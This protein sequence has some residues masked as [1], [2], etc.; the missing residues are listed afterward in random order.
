MAGLILSL[1]IVGG[2]VAS[3]PDAVVAQ[4]P[5]TE[6]IEVRVAASTDDAEEAPDGGM[7]LSSSDLELVY[8]GGNQT[9]GMRFNG[10]HIP[11]G[12]PIVNAYLQ[13]Q[14]DETGSIETSLTIA[15]QDADNAAT[16][17]SSDF[18][19]SSRPRT[20]ATVAWSPAP[21]LLK[22]EAGPDQR[23]PDI[24]SVIQEIVDRPGWVSGNSLAIIVTGTGER[25]AES[26]NGDPA[27]AP[28]LRVEYVAGQPPVTTI[29]APLDGATFTTEDLITFSGS[30]TDPEDGDVTASLSWVSNL[31]GPLGNG[32]IFTHPGLSAGVHTITATAIDSGG[33]TGSDQITITVTSPSGNLSPVVSAGPDQAI[34][35]FDVAILDGT[36]S[37][38]GL[39]DPPAVVTTTWHQVSG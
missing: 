6:A 39:P 9:V 30:A 34:G 35:L 23:S 10:V 32:G 38:D 21:W 4:D 25:G 12:A 18:D 2:L 19:I 8:D 20:A 22:G 13:F 33:W 31:D 5:L 7:Y 26:Y 15:G 17:A 11:Q 16:F 24:A 28:L 29:S 1:A 37:D 27:G 3:A 36:V 14:V